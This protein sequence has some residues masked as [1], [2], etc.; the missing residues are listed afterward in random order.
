MFDVFFRS[1]DYGKNMGKL[2]TSVLKQQWRFKGVWNYKEQKFVV[3][4]GVTVWSE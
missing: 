1:G 2:L 4:K 3:C